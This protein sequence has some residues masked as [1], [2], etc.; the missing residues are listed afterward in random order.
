M[1]RRASNGAIVITT[2]TGKGYQS[3]GKRGIG[4]SVNSGVAFNNVYVLPDLPE[5]LWRWAGTV[6]GY[7]M[8]DGSYMPD[9]ALDGSWGPRLTAAWCA[10][11]TA[12]TIM[13]E[14]QASE[15]SPLGA[16]PTTWSRLLPDRCDPDQQ[17]QRDGSDRREFFPLELHQP[18]P[19]GCL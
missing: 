6:L 15:R 10:I 14:T 18:R 13:K 17:R 11:G 19:D 7:T 16:Q 4:I 5:Q 9:Y 12:G 1:D 8:P 3:S 2:K